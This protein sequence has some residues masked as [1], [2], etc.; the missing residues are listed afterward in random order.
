MTQIMHNKQVVYANNH[1]T[2][3]HLQ[4]IIVD[5]QHAVRLDKML[6]SHTVTENLS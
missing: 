4:D 5:M 3:K 2:N 6:I 1:I